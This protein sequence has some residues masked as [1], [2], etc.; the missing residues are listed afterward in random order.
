MNFQ[1]DFWQVSILAF[2]SNFDSGA[3]SEQYSNS[4]PGFRM[5]SSIY[6][7]RESFEVR[8]NSVISFVSVAF[9]QPRILRYSVRDVT[10][11]HQIFSL[12]R[13]WSKQVT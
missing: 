9:C 13:H 1:H 4:L 8:F 10:D 2:P 6:V 11:I 5:K 12:A 3:F 7:K